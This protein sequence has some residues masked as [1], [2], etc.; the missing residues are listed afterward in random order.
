[1]PLLEN[2]EEY[3]TVIDDMDTADE[4]RKRVRLD[5][6]ADVTPTTEQSC[7]NRSRYHETI[8]HHT[9]AGGT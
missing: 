4:K 1:M 7:T 6:E 2:Y 3:A 5:E 8:R 9:A